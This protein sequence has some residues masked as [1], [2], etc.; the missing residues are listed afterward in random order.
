MIRYIRDGLR[1]AVDLPDW[2]AAVKFIL[3]EVPLAGGEDLDC[4]GLMELPGDQLQTRLVLIK[5]Q[6]S[7]Y[8]SAGAILGDKSEMLR[9]TAWFSCNRG[10]GKVEA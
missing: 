2:Q 7:T 8:V 5:N 10:H 4:H 6:G 9:L 1:S 3:T